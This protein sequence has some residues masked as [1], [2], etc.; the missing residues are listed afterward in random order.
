MTSKYDD[1]DIFDPELI[2][3][4]E[5]R[6]DRPKQVEEKKLPLTKAEQRKLY[7]AKAKERSDKRR[8]NH[9]R[10]T[11]DYVQSLETELINARVYLNV[12][13]LKE[14]FNKFT[15]KYKVKENDNEDDKEKKS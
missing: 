2:Y 3:P 4:S 1:L 5:I 7:Q 11:D 8:I 9:I 15:D 14:D 6:G 13:N 10:A 12:K